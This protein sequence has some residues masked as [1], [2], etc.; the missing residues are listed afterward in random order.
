MRKIYNYFRHTLQGKII[1]SFFTVLVLGNIITFFITSPFIIK[2]L[3]NKVENNTQGIYQFHRIKILILTISCIISVSALC[4]VSRIIVKQIKI[5]TKATNEVAEGNFDV[6]LETKEKDEIGRLIN[7]FNKMTKN[8]KHTAYIQKDFINNVSHEFKTPIASIQGFA[9]ILK[10]DKLSKE[11][12]QEYLDIIIEEAKR[13]E[14]LS[15]NVLKLSKLENQNV[16]E[17]QQ[18]FSLDEQIRRAILILEN[19]WQEKEIKFNLDLKKTYFYG[20]EELLLQVWINIIG[21]AIKFSNRN[22]SINIKIESNVE[23][24]LVIIKDNGVGMDEDTLV[25]IFDKFYQGDNSRSLK[26][27]GLGL[28]ITKRIV[29]LSNG[30]II[31]ESSIGEGS[32]FYI[33]LFRE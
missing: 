21:N 25:H 26:G 23:F 15:D 18:K 29:E 9:K 30:E 33:K 6:Y 27:Y 24:V 22:Q 11:D 10:N 2:V 17:N 12:R 7:H 28:A 5:L 8:L 1:F 16:L 13:L 32:T 31:V 19:N 4:V 20:Q 14:N 3:G